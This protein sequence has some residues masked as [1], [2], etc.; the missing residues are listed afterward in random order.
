MWFSGS[1]HLL[2][3]HEGLS[4]NSQHL[5]FKS[6]ALCTLQC[7]AGSVLGGLGVETGGW[8]EVPTANLALGS[9]RDLVFKRVS[10][11]VTEQDR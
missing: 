2:L 3:K 8:L 4:S 9:V 6:C 5:H 11:R 1:E 7:C 10:R